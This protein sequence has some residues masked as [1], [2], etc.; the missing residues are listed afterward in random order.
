MKVIYD[1]VFVEFNEIIIYGMIDL[2]IK[3]WMYVDIG[4]WFFGFV[5]EFYL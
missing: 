5:V 1:I 4:C 3:F 2:V